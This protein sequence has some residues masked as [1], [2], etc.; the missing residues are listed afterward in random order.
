MEKE[1]YGK[2]IKECNV[3]MQGGIEYSL[4]NYLSGIEKFDKFLNGKPFSE[5]AN[6]HTIAW[7]EHAIVFYIFN[8]KEMLSA[9]FPRSE[10][11]EII[12]HKN[13]KID[14]YDVNF[15]TKLKHGKIGSGLLGGAV[16][17]A[18]GAI[19]DAVNDKIDNKSSKKVDGSVFEFIFQK[20]DN[21]KY[22]ITVSSE[23]DNLVHT[24]SF[25]IYQ[26]ITVPPEPSTSGACYIAT[27]C[28]GDDMSLEVIK[29]REFRDKILKNSYL[30]RKFIRFYYNHAEDLSKRLINK[31]TTN[32]I[33]KI[34][35][36][37]PLYLWIK[38]YLNYQKR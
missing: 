2:L 9:A 4:F 20:M 33:I 36:L 7:F 18:V 14:I 38:Y 10:L 28:Y 3:I 13:V 23:K 32:R 6:R 25:L 15:F 22:S 24:F 16:F 37:N 30:G 5:T 26:H 35:I 19:G 29:F 12:E 17:K 1:D 11:L 21:E 8:D 31:R 27:V 34:L